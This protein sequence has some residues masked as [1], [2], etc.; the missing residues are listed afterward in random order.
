MTRRKVIQTPKGY[1]SYS[2][3]Q[4][5]KADKQRYRKLYFAN[6]SEHRLHNKEM[7][8]GKIED[9]LFTGF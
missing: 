7:E 2:Q 5:W 6:K 3:I 9:I 8:Y 4:L 1:L